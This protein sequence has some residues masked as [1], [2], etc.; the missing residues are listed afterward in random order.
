MR[1]LGAWL[2]RLTAFRIGLFTGLAFAALH[3]LQLA[4]RADVPL[5]TRMEG[6]LTDL[7]FLQ[8]VQLGGSTPSGQVVVAAVD[9]AAIAKFGRFPWDRRVIAALIDKLDEQ[10][11]TAIGFDMSFSDED[12]GAKFAGAKRFRKRFED[13]SLAAP[14]N[15][16]AVDQFDQAESDLTGAAS[17]LSGL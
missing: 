5:L 12:L 14:Q 16:S 15:R 17:A 6:A 2:T 9:E 1:R 13:I 7:R 10:G 4:G 3:L 11:V 8:R